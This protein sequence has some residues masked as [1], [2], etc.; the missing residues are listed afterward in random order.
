MKLRVD[1]FETGGIDV[2]IDLSRRDIGMPQ[3]FLDDAQ[4]SPAAKQMGGEAMP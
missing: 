2:G 1:G 3:Q 4:I